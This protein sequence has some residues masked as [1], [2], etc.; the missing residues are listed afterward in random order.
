MMI[1][2]LLIDVELPYRVLGID[3]QVD[4]FDIPY[5]ATFYITIAILMSLTLLTIIASLI[6]YSQIRHQKRVNYFS[7]QS[8]SQIFTY[9]QNRL[10]VFNGLKAYS[11]LWVIFGH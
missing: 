8:S 7:I 4:Q 10:N 6:K 2:K 3:S 11:M 9:K 5:S 1:D